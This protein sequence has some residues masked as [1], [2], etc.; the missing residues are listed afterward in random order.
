MAG[1]NCKGNVSMQDK[2]N[3]NNSFFQIIVKYALK[4]LVFLLFLIGIPFINLYIIYLSFNIIVLNKSID[5][6]PLLKSIGQKFQNKDEEI[7]E[8]IDDEEF[9][10]LT[11][12][13]V[14]LL[15]AEDITEQQMKN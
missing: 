9:N 6:K 13:D 3:E 14:V 8:Y 1:C 7:D 12:D 11:E 10:N 5:I 15:N 2:E 4:T